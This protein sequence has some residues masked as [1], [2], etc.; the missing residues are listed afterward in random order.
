MTTQTFKVGDKVR[1]TNKCPKGWWFGPHTEYL[2]G[3]IT[4]VKNDPQL[5]TYRIKPDNSADGWVGHCDGEHMELIKEVVPEETGTFIISLMEDGEY[6]PA[7]IPKTYKTAA[8]ARAVAR[9]M[10][11]EHVERFA[12]FKAVG[13]AVPV[14]PKKVESSYTTL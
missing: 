6:K 3:V 8:Q 9:K 11:E 4:G 7:A 1:F 5:Y 10:A 14:V 13:F 2:T 12:V